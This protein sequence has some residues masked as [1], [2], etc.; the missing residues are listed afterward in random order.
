MTILKNPAL[1]VHG[2]IWSLNVTEREEHVNNQ[3]LKSPHLFFCLGFTFSFAVICHSVLEQGD[4]RVSD[5]L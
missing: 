3:M 2:G 1:K 5:A 4:N